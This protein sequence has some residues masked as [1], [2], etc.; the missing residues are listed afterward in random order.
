MNPIDLIGRGVGVATGAVRVATAVPR[1]A[2]NLLVHRDNDDNGG[3][4]FAAATAIERDDER[5]AP[6]SPGAA[7]RP[8]GGTGRRAPSPKATPG[9]AKTAGGDVEVTTGPPEPT[10]AAG[11]SGGVAG[12]LDAPGDAAAAGAPDP[13]AARVTTA[14]ATPRIPQGERRASDVRP[15]PSRRKT[16]DTEETLVETE[17]AASPGP[18]IRV[19]APFEGYEKLKAAEIVARVREADESTKA[20]VRLYES[21]HKKRKSI[22]DAT[23]T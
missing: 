15:Q 8:P 12:T 4:P 13:T 14:R 21:T 3:D 7:G 17:G 22:L 23:T 10:S 16:V 20:V 19:D 5:V 18:Q 1:L 9:R 11:A 6:P 2:L